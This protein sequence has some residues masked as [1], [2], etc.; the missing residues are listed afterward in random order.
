MARSF[1]YALLIGALAL[2]GCSESD[3]PSIAPRAFSL[4]SANGA[5]PPTTIATSAG[6]DQV[7]LSGQVLLASDH[8]FSLDGSVA[9]DCSGVGGTYEVHSLS[10]AGSYTENGQDITFQLPGS[11]PLSAQLAGDSLSSTLPASP[12]TFAA[13]AALVFLRRPRA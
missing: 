3:G 2:L 7:L 11:P 8:T 5:A 4:V 12:F 9:L 6:C 1:Q 10:L 13:P